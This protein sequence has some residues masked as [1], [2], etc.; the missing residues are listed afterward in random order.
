[1]LERKDHTAHRVADLLLRP[2]RQQRRDALK[3]AVHGRPLQRA[4]AD[5][6]RVVKRRVRLQQA[7]QRLVLAAVRCVVDR[8]RRLRTAEQH[9]AEIRSD[10][11]T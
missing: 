6:V 5:A 4:P 1:M 3:V 7:E 8:A 11:Y 2:G 9:N 10:R